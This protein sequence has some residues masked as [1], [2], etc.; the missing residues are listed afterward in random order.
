M[1]D[2]P[3][4]LSI[5][6][7]L[8]IS[9]LLGPVAFADDPASMT[10]DSTG[11]EVT[12][13]TTAHTTYTV[14][15]STDLATWDPFAEVE[16]DGHAH[17]MPLH[18]DDASEEAVFY[19]MDKRYHFA[20]KG[21]GAQKSPTF[22]TTDAQPLMDAMAAM[23]LSWYYNW[24]LRKRNLYT[25]MHGIEFV[26]MFWGYN[27][28]WGEGFLEGAMQD[29]DAIAAD[30]SITHLLGFNEPDHSEQSN[31]T[32]EQALELWPLLEAT[33][34]RL[35]SPAPA[36]KGAALG[37]NNWLDRFMKG[38]AERGYR[39]DFI[40]LHIYQEPHNINYLLDYVEDAYEKY[41]LPIWI[42]EWS[43]VNWTGV[44]PAEDKQVAYLTEV[45]ERL[46][47]IPY[48]ER[49]A[50]FNI[51]DY[52]EPSQTDTWDMGLVEFEEVLDR[53]DGRRVSRWEIELTAVGEA[54]RDV[55]ADGLPDPFVEP[56]PDPDAGIN[57]VLNPGLEED[58]TG[59]TTWVRDEVSTWLVSAEAHLTP[60][61][62][63]LTAPVAFQGTLSQTFTDLPTGLY[64]IR[65]H[66]KT[67][68][69]FEATKIQVYINDEWQGIYSAD[70][71]TSADFVE[72][73]NSSIFV[74][75][76]DRLQF[77]IMAKG[78]AGAE[79]YLDDIYFGK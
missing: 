1:K 33:G 49:H 30:D 58:F 40:C 6:C 60:K 47:N 79:L 28:A 34:K 64:N 29:L 7:A 21:V 70:F 32:V 61:S 52:R 25:D 10:L 44:S 26:P 12:V 57:L 77:R 72:T 31:M 23:N 20:K 76:G 48:V 15:R 68:G 9:S 65:I 74:S 11:S 22:G 35:G 36:G 59:W 51:D 24:G 37:N 8:S 71:P 55:L 67:T 5:F 45:I 39:V 18:E 42:T 3:K 16:G 62:A 38:C 50:W 17:A 46:E 54:M 2:I 63:Y 66:S 4:L 73:V 53:V 14:H 56:D 78:D 41:G 43:L 75:E 27:E 69:T 19:R 13:A